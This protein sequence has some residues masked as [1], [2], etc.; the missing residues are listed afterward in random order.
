M[1]SKLSRT[2]ATK[3]HLQTQKALASFK[4]S[5]SNFELA[6]TFALKLVEIEE[7]F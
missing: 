6:A 2:D 5:L 7:S 4:N 1:P 3:T